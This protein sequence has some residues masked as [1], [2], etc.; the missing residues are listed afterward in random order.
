MPTFTFIAD[1]NGGTYIS[2]SAGRFPGAALRAWLQSFD[3]SVIPQLSACGVQMLRRDL[4]ADTP[5]PVESVRSVWCVSAVLP[6]GLF[7]LHIIETRVR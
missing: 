3:F 6:R 5:I 4:S 2:Q 1:Y 7:L